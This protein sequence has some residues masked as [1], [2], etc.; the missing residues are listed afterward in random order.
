MAR[1][2]N[3]GVFDAQRDDWTSYSKRFLKYFTANKVEGAEKRRAILF[4]VAVTYQLIRDLVAPKK[5]TE[6]TS[7]ELVTVVQR[8]YQ[9]RPSVIV[10]RLKFNLRAQQL[11]ESVATF[12][13]ELG[14]LA[15]HCRYGKSL[16]KMLRD[17][18][19]CGIT[20]N[21]LQ[22]RLLV[23]PDLTI[24]K[25]ALELAQA[26]ESADQVS[27]QLQQQQKYPPRVTSECTQI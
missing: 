14:R 19:V 18:I 6:K 8:H 25:K 15:E 27:Q 4:S 21:Q 17:R 13:S 3:I 20:D 9:P 26:Q 16:K 23:E 10:Q 12:I 24:I 5:P 11:S 22:K 7:G 1:H 2:R